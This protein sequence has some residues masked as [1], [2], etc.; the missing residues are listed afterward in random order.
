MNQAYSRLSTTHGHITDCKLLVCMYWTRLV[1]VR[2]AASLYSASPLKHLGP[3]RSDLCVGMKRIC[4]L[5]GL[6]VPNNLSRLTPW[7]EA[8]DRRRSSPSSPAVTLIPAPTTPANPASVINVSS[9]RR[10]AGWHLK[11]GTIGRRCSISNLHFMHNVSRE[12]NKFSALMCS[13]RSM[14]LSY[15]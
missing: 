14:P 4:S 12:T 1:L 8:D 7:Q 2:P 15:W 10:L 9:W 13:E 3:R 5:K 11:F 6:W